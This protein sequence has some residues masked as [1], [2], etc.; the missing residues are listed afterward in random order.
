MA[1]PKRKM[2]KARSGK[3]STHWKQ[4]LPQLSK[5]SHC[6]QVILSHRVCH[7]CG[8]YGGLEIITPAEE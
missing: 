4:K 2:S 1:V 7:N 6:G 3:K 5:C 8:Y